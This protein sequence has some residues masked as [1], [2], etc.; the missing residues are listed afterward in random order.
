MITSPDYKSWIQ[1]VFDR[2]SKDYGVVGSGYFDQ[3]GKEL[4]AFSKLNA[5]PCL[6]DVATGKGA[7]LRALA[8]KLQNQ[9]SIYGIDLSNEMVEATRSSPVCKK[10]NNIHLQQ[11][12]AENLKFPD[13]F[14][15]AIFCGFGL[16]FFPNPEKALTEFKLVLKPN[17]HLYASLW[18]GDTELDL[19]I[20][21]KIKNLA[22]NSRSIV[23]NNLLSDSTALREL[24]LKVGF[25]Q[26]RIQNSSVTHTY[27]DADE[28]WNSLWSHAFRGLFE[29]LDEQQ[30]KTLKQESFEEIQIHSKHGKIV[31]EIPALFI[32]AQVR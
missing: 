31:E 4:V 27:Q 29:Q 16:F 11:M 10:F 22:L 25:E 5:T 30:I 3:F 12:D 2:S 28:W 6:L 14:F 19:I 32:E 13:H 7:I 23:A 18:D 15:D 26:L 8:E 20:Q 21:E 24:L 9:G 1:G 17:G